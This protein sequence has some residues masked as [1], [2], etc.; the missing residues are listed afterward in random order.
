MRIDFEI[1][2]AVVTEFDLGESKME[3]SVCG[4]VREVI[5]PVLLSF[6][7]TVED[8]DLVDDSEDAETRGE[9]T[10]FDEEILFSGIGTKS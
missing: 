5:R 4:A 1:S 9:D 7:A 10:N 6:A 2:P 3:G 8:A